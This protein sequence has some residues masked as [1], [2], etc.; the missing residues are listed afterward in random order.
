ML[1][2][3]DDRLITGSVDF[4]TPIKKT[5]LK[6]GLEK[7]K[8]TPAAVTVVKEDR[9][10]FGLLVSKAG[11]LEEAFTHPITTVPLLIATADSTLRQSDKVTL[12][13]FLL[14]ESQCIKDVPPK[15][16]VW[17]VDGMAAVRCLKPNQCNKRGSTA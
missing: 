11:S 5:K 17:I 3:I 8:R 10:A 16:A 4:F 9:Q 13:R 15:S 14:E 12:Q 1:R 7:V 6:T 2:F